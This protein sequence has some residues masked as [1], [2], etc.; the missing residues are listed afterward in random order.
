NN[1]ASST[2]LSNSQTTT[3]ICHIGALIAVTFCGASFESSKGLINEGLGPVEIYIYRFVLAYLLVLAGCH[4]KLWANSWRDE[5]LFLVC[6]LC[7]S[8]IYFIAEN[9]AV[10]YTRVSDVS[11]ITTLSPLLTTLLIGALYK[12][13]RPG[14]W[15]YISSMIAFMGVGCIVFKDGLQGMAD[16]PDALSTAIGDLLAL[17]AAFSWAIYS[18]VLRKLN[19]TYSAQ[20][21]TRKTFFYGLVTAVPFWIVSKEPVVELSTLLEPAVIGNLLFLGV[22]CSVAAYTLWA[23]VMSK[24]GAITTNNYLYIQPICTMIIAACLFANDP[25]TFMG[26]FGAL[27]IIGGLWFGDLMGRR[28]SRS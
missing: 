27:L 28:E 13:E 25:I 5:M 2:R 1:M 10:N 20:F 6:G 23:L 3:L 7:G 22:L 19:V 26:C 21:V 24:L 12:A 16:G 9:N 8:S 17:G 14:K 15:T 11:M 18:V 4:R